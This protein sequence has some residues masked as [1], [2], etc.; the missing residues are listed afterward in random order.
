[1]TLWA[2]I[3][4]D[5]TT[6]FA[7][8]LPPTAR[9]AQNILWQWTQTHEAPKLL[10][11]LTTGE[12]SEGEFN[13]FFKVLKLNWGWHAG[14]KILLCLKQ[15]PCQCW[16][17]FQGTYLSALELRRK[18]NAGDKSTQLA[19]QVFPGKTLAMCLPQGDLHPQFQLTSFSEFAMHSP[20][21]HMSFIWKLQPCDLYKIISQSCF[22]W[23]G[24][25]CGMCPELQ[26]QLHSLL[27]TSYFIMI[28]LV[29]Q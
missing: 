14:K 16:K 15:F 26:K 3:D 7:F 5:I 10:L 6:C 28:L 17:L 4:T 1:M 29:Y 23:T 20:S 9:L 27:Y 12:F 13:S 22:D 18:S 2:S 11:T 8:S 24:V 25:S 19:H 21:G